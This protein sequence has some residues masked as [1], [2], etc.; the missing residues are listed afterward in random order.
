M[1]QNKFYF[2]NTRTGR[3]R[4]AMQFAIECSAPAGEADTGGSVLTTSIQAP[5]ASV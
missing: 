4:K 1:E 3:P 5:A 2:I